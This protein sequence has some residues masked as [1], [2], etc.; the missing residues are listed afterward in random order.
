MDPT[1]TSKGRMRQNTELSPLHCGKVL[2]L[3]ANRFVPKFAAR[4]MNFEF[5]G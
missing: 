3:I 4:W 1:G 2:K 5:T